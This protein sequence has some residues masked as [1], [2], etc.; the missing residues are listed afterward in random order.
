MHQFGVH[1]PL[2]TA[3]RTPGMRDRHWD[4]ISQQLG[5]AFKPEEDVT[6]AALLQRYDLPAHLSMFQ[7]CVRH[8]PRPFSHLAHYH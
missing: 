7:V 5:F 2:I 6:F 4:E 1:V 3:L 8:S